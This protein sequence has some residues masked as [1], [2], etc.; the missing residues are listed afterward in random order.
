MAQVELN[1]GPSVKAA[2]GF[3][4][5]FVPAPRFDVTVPD[6]MSLI[7]SSALSPAHGNE[8]SGNRKDGL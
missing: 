2:I 7:G 3:V 1:P 5:T 4:Q 8:T 6:Q